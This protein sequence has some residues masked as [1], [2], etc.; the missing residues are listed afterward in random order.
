MKTYLCGR[1]WRTCG[2]HELRPLR[3]LLPDKIFHTA[4]GGGDNHYVLEA[5][6]L[7]PIADGDAY[8]RPPHTPLP[9]DT[10]FDPALPPDVQ[11]CPAYDSVIF[12]VLHLRDCLVNHAKKVTILCGPTLWFRSLLCGA[13]VGV[14]AVVYRCAARNFWN[15]L[16]S[17]QGLPLFWML[18]VCAA[19]VFNH[20]WHVSCCMTACCS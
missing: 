14:V 11:A 18:R 12:I 15:F 20:S 13:S 4:E 7:R 9:Q 19:S 3:R 17:N 6:H 8:L 16:C 10:S 1:Q 5:A 2:L